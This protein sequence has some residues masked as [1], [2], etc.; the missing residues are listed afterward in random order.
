MKKP[1]KNYAF[2][3]SQNL[4]LAIRNLGWKLDFKRFRIYLQEHYGVT[5]A[6]LFIGFIDGNTT[7]YTTLQ[8]AGLFVFSNPLLYTKM[9][10]QKVTVM[11]NLYYKQ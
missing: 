5:K 8:E 9:V 1:L 4:N 6:F 2:I 11:L 7:L 10:K 3:D